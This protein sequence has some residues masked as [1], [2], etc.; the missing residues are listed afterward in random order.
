MAA[1]RKSTSRRSS[2][3][4]SQSRNITS[5]VLRGFAIILVLLLAAVYVVHRTTTPSELRRK[6][7]KAKRVAK[8]YLPPQEQEP[9]TKPEHSPR[10]MQPQ[11]PK[12]AIVIDDFGNSISIAQSFFTLEYPIGISI[13]PFTPYA[14]QIA[15]QAKS[16]G[17]AVLLHLPMEPKGYPK[18]DP[19][20]GALL[21]EDSS[22]TILKKIND[23]IDSLGVMPDGVNHHMGSAFTAN[24]TQMSMA[25]NYIGNKGLFYLDS[26]TSSDSV[27][28]SLALG[29][30]IRTAKRDVFLDNSSDPEYIEQQV[31][32]LCEKAEEHGSAIGIGHA[33]KNT[34][35]VLD[36]ML[37]EVER[38]GYLV[39]DVR[40]LL[41]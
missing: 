30:G 37:P 6:L 19:G 9:I 1:K 24:A 26:L 21:L 18:V 2:A 4:K 33:R 39:V 34:F 3:K 5:I 16:E 28:Y 10:F 14:S 36:T 17:F 38:R 25:L 13:L 27:A 41:N 31:W 29:A 40:E 23:A 22:S 15:R 35:Q 12:I 8:Q 11:A 20:R 32:A 7:E